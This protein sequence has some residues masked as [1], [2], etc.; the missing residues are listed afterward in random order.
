MSKPPLH[1]IGMFGI[2][3]NI[4]QRAVIL[5]LMEHYDVWLET[6]HVWIYHDMI[7][8]GLKLILRTTTLWMHV[9]NI[10]T[11]RHIHPDVYQPRHKI[12]P[13]TRQIRIWYLK[14]GI[15]QTGSIIAAMHQAAGLNC[16]RPDF[17]LPMRQE[18]YTPRVHDIVRA[19]RDGRP[20]MIYRPIVLRKEW[21]SHLRNPDPA[22]YEELYASI[23]KEFYTISIASLKPSI[24]WIVGREQDAD[25]KIHD[26]SLQMWEMAALFASADI[27]FCNA[28][29][30]P[31]LAQ[32]VRTPVITVYGGRESYR[33]TQRA[34]EHL[35][36]SLGIDPDHT[37]DCHSHTHHCNKY[38]NV[39]PAIAK[40]RSFI[41]AN[42]II[43]H[44]LRGYVGETT[45]HEPMDGGGR[46][47]APES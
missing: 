37:C 31:V 14:P 3:D 5:R 11:E 8:R 24:E 29:M 42:V 36:P 19:R 18:W 41:D 35:V 46:T 27:V 40:I 30:A 34:G 23:R 17:T 13:G 10:D 28:G 26:G 21:D 4:H 6:C 38:I 33:T 12:P 2:G 39:P 25:M 7:E 16:D 45:H 9:Q 20:V 15:D 44:D 32:S 1:V 47:A 22:H 43:R